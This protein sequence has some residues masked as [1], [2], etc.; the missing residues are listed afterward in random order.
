[1]TTFISDSYDA[2]EETLTQINSFKLKSYPGKNVT[3]CCAVILV[4]AECLE[5]S[6]AF[7]PEHLGYITHIFEDTSEF[8]F[9]PWA[10][11]KYK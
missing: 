3:Y 8:R 6:G 2:L 1:M 9:R 10:I 5:T 7:K 4:D 11:Q